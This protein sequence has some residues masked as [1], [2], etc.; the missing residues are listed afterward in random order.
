MDS[1]SQMPIK[2]DGV[3]GRGNRLH[4]WRLMEVDG[5]FRGGDRSSS[6]GVRVRAELG[7]MELWR[8]DGGVVSSTAVGG[9]MAMFTDAR[10]VGKTQIPKTPDS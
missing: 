3:N 1:I 2:G 4:R 7:S 8:R 10:A 6:Y 5:D 9:V